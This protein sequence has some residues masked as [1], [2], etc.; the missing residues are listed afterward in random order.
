MHMLHLGR[1][2]MHR[3]PL[4]RFEICTP[5]QVMPADAAHQGPH[6]SQVKVLSEFHGPHDLGPH[7]LGHHSDHLGEPL[8]Q[9]GN[10]DDLGDDVGDEANYGQDATG[11]VLVDAQDADG[12]H[13]HAAT[14]GLHVYAHA[15]DGDGQDDGHDDGQA[16]GHHAHQQQSEYHADCHD[17]G[18]SEHQHQSEHHADVHDADLGDPYWL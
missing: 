3:V 11:G 15:A 13:V 8:H 1:L 12:V 6:P 16:K 5:L 17:D 10:A 2:Q 7:E 18:Q 4:V 14:G 9:G